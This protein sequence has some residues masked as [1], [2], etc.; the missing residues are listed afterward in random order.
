MFGEVKDLV[1][2]VMLE[3]V[4]ERVEEGDYQD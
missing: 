1:G 3:V 4:G 2:E